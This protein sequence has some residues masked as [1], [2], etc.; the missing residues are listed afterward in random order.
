MKKVIIMLALVASSFVM[1]AQ[2]RSVNLELL[3][4]SG[5]A[6]VNYDAR[7]NGNSG[8]GYSVGLGYGFS[9]GTSV[10]TTHELGIPVE[11]NYLWG[12]N[13]SHFVLGAGAYAGISK[14]EKS[15]IQFGGNIFAD[16]AYSYQRPTGFT[17]AIGVKP[18]LS[19]AFWPYISLGYSF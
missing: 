18:N 1:N 4:S 5:L 8:F 16:I 2:T 13:S 12:R 9:A 19:K 17:F 11:L 15:D 6:G 3:G 7:F 10:P 14:A